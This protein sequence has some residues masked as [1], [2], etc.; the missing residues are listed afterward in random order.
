ML[1]NR[2]NEVETS[3]LKGIGKVCK[4]VTG[5]CLAPKGAFE[6]AELAVSL[7]RYLDTELGAFS[8]TKPGAFGRLQKKAG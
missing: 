5:K 6:L 3:S 1:L 4:G 8:D 7:K 2:T